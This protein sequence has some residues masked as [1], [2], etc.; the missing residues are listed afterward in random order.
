VKSCRENGWEYGPS[1]LV[2]VANVSLASAK[3]DLVRDGRF[4][5][6]ESFPVLAALMVVFI[7]N[8]HNLTLKFRLFYKATLKSKMQKEPAPNF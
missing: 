6:M 8:R 1:T 4:T 5:I 3:G 7:G 2:A